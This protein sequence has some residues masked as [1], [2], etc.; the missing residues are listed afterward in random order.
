[1]SKQMLVIVGVLA[2]TFL[3]GIAIGFFL[4]SDPSDSNANAK[5][6]GA[7]SSATFFTDNAARDREQGNELLSNRIRELDKELADAKTDQRAI[8]ADRLAFFNKFHDRISVQPFSYDLKVTP[9]MAAL[10]GLT[11]AETKAIEQHLAET[12]AE[13]DKL[14]DADTVLSKQTENSVTYD[15][16]ADKQGEA[17]KDQLRGLLTGDLGEDRADLFMGTNS[18]DYNIQLDGFLADKRKIAI[19]WTEQNNQRTYTVE[20]ITGTGSS[21]M[22]VNGM[23]QP[24]FQKYL[25]EGMKP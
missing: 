21:T 5:I 22:R 17:L 16:A 25:P 3:A 6:A 8:L 23:L 11:P 18:Y 2:A 7:G 15:I 19:S 24:Q 10:L 14:Q 1:M 13:L 12:K 4:A 9:E 20:Q